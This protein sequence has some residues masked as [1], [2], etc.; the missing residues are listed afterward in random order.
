VDATEEDFRHIRTG[1]ANPVMLDGIKVDY[2]GTPTPLEQVGNITVPEPR[3]LVISPWDKSLLGPISK[4]ILN[5]DLSL[6]P[7]NDGQVLRLVLPPLTEER[8]KEFAKLTGKKAEEGKIA[9]R[10][11]RRDA[12]E[13][14]KKGEKAMRHIRN[15]GIAMIFQDPM[16]SLNPTIRV[17]TQIAERI[18]AFGKGVSKAEA[19]RQA[20]ELLRQVS[21]PEPEKTVKDG[22]S[23]R[24]DARVQKLSRLDVSSYL[25]RLNR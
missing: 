3:M 25:V 22:D 4:A 24:T 23:M 1:R 11:V 2:Y 14:L 5:S 15:S 20:V 18:L 21:I 19:W 13:H 9:I 12:I 6:N 10:N 17:G 16:T 7:S 8:R